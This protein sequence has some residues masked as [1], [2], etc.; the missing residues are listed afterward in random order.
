MS[1]LSFFSRQSV[2][3]AVVGDSGMSLGKEKR[4][5]KTF[6]RKNSSYLE[7]KRVVFVIVFKIVSECLG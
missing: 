4:V 6:N 2:A 3:V 7:S 5:G 1:T